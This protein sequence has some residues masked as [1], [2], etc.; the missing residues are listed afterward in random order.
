[1][2]KF[3]QTFL[4]DLQTINGQVTD[5][6]RKVS[7]LENELECL[8][9]L[10][11]KTRKCLEALET[12][13]SENYRLLL[14]TRWSDMEEGTITL[15]ANDYFQFW[16]DIHTRDEIYFFKVTSS[17]LPFYWNEPEM[18]LYERTLIKSIEKF[19][20]YESS[21]RETAYG[22]IRKEVSSIIENLVS[23]YKSTGIR[24]ELIKARVQ[25]MIE[26]NFERIFILDPRV[27]E[28]DLELLAKII[29]RQRSGNVK[30]RVVGITMNEASTSQRPHDFGLVLTSNGDLFGMFCDVDR[31][32]NP[33]GGRVIT[34][35]E[36]ISD[37]IDCYLRIRGKSEEIASNQSEEAIQSALARIQERGL[38]ISHREIYENRCYMCLR[39]AERIINSGQWAN[40]QS[41]LKTW[42][43]I[44]HDEHERLTE[45]LLDTRGRDVL[46]IGCGPGRVPNL[47]MKLVAEN[48]LPTPSRVVAYEQN[49][50]ISNYCR[51]DLARHAPLVTVQTQFVGF[52]ADGRYNG[53]LPGDRDFDLILAVSNLV[54]WQGDNEAHWL[55]RVVEDG[56]R[57][58][59]RLFFTV[60]K[61]GFELERARMYKAAGD[62]IDVNSGEWSEKRDI[63]IFADAFGN[64][65]HKSKAYDQQEIEAIIKKVQDSGIAIDRVDIKSVGKYMW[66]VSL[67]R[68]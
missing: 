63:T 7:S 13:R 33:I 36:Q 17:I 27:T 35:K 15:T 60:Y 21:K 18:K 5:L 31:F 55:A 1:V 61:R 23:R 49:P 66:G 2:P 10:E 64:E 53:L 9:N 48:V 58:G 19:L 41:A 26:D 40:E 68:V 57:Q 8:K 22:R 3:K 20:S 50:E 32:G 39:K 42:F 4:E 44:V 43:E 11:P 30:I 56:L 47:I 45:V 54:G 46:E 51:R 29:K 24:E 6:M 14:E 59:G 28:K 34:N 52:Q 25:N 12:S 37:Y 38:D 67:V 65:R 16:T 62:L